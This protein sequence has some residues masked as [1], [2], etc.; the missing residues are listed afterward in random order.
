MSNNNISVFLMSLKIVQFTPPTSSYCSLYPT[1]RYALY[2][3]VLYC[4]IT[5]ANFVYLYIQSNSISPN[6]DRLTQ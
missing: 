4:N 1:L 6:S 3:R 5:T 2:C